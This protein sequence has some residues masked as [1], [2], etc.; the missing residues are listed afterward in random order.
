MRRE[1]PEEVT[2]GG[3]ASRARLTERDRQL[4][5]LLGLS[6]YLTEAQIAEG[7]YPGL[8]L[9]NMRKRLLRL[10][11]R[12]ASAF[13]KAYLRRL[14]HRTWDGQLVPTWTM[15]ELGYRV[16]AEVAGAEVK[17]SAR[18]SSFGSCSIR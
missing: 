2:Q 8:N 5:G 16:G 6:H 17:C 12:G 13:S 11:G 7:L 1:R 10:S 18:T 3:W 14:Y 9:Q 15:T 4:M